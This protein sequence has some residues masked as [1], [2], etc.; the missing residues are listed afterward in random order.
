[1][2]VR[3]TPSGAPVRK[4][5]RAGGVLAGIAVTGVVLA[6]LVAAVME[7]YRWALAHVDVIAGCAALLLLALVVLAAPVRRC[8]VDLLSKGCGH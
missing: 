5:R 4:R 2:P 8:C 6:G 7:L 1:M 3:V